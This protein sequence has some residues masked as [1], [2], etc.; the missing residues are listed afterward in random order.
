MKKILAGVIIPALIFSFAGLS[1]CKNKTTEKQQ[2]KAEIEQVKTLENQIEEHVYPLPT[3]A[4]VIK[5]LS[6]LEVGY[7]IWISNPVENS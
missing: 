4:E 5:M 2:K 6:D 3:S 1:S 7:I